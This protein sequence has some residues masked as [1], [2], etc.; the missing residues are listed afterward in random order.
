[1]PRAN[2]KARALCTQAGSARDSILYTG[3]TPI[4]IR[5]AASLQ[6]QFAVNRVIV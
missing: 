1:M 3:A 2:G 5:G 6:P 4:G